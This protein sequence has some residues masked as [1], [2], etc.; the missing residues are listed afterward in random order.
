MTLTLAFKVTVV[1]TI[2]RYHDQ[3]SVPSPMINMSKVSGHNVAEDECFTDLARGK[4][5]SLTVCSDV[6]L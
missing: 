1:L 4:L 2:F 6:A 3:C 5:K